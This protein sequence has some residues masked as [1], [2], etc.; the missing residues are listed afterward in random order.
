MKFLKIILS[1]VSG[2]ALVVFGGAFLLPEHT[3]VEEIKVLNIPINTAFYQI[4]NLNNWNNWSPWHKMTN[5]KDTKYIYGTTIQGKGAN[6]SWKSKNK[7][8]G[9]GSLKITESITNELVKTSMAFEGNGDATSDF[10]LKPSGDGTEITW[11]FDS[12]ATGAINKWMSLMMKSQL[13]KTFKQ[14]FEYLEAYATEHP[15]VPEIDVFVD[16]IPQ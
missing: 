13:K 11:T 8:I 1:I 16:T 5:E 6:Y 2:L 14:G 7:M 15:E 10:I 3:H 9:N 4:N 12:D